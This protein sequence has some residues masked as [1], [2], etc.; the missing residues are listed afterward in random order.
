MTAATAASTRPAWS[1]FGGGGILLAATLLFVATILEYVYWVVAEADSPGLLVAVV[2]TLGASILLYAA[3]V[4]PLAFG[5]R[6]SNGIVGRSVLGKV[7]LLAFGLGFAV[8]ETLY[9][10]AT[11]GIGAD[12]GWGA[13]VFFVVQFVGIVVAAIV[14]ARA[15]I[16]TGFARWSLLIGS[17]LALVCSIVVR[18]TDSF[19]VVTVAYCVST[20]IQAIVG[21]SYL[22][23]GKRTSVDA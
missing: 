23:A 3:A 8:A 16:A 17:A 4:F 13:M 2:V 7:A 11:Y 9:L 10:I 6:G 18:T 21:A 20:V 12:P 22:A 5:S 19:E 14:I 15:S 1:T